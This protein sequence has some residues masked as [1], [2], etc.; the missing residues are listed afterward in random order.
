MVERGAAI[1][2]L[3]HGGNELAI[4]VRLPPRQ[5][6]DIGM[7]E[8]GEQLA[9]EPAL[10]AR[11][12]ALRDVRVIVG[13]SLLPLGFRDRA[14]GAVEEETGATAGRARLTR[15]DAQLHYRCV[16]RVRGLRTY[17]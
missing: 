16:R 5:D 8:V 15:L 9:L 13:Q 14:L 1:G 6:V 11:K 7:L 10:P 4:D 12:P 3:L 17:G 2:K